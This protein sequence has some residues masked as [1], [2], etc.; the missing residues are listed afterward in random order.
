M[1]GIIG[2]TRIAQGCENPPKTAD[3][4]DKI[5]TSSH[6]L[7]GLV[8]DVLDMSRIE[9]GK[10]KLHPEPY[11]KREFVAYLEAVVRPLCDEKSQEFLIMDEGNPDTVAILDKLR[12][13]Q[14]VFNLLSNA[15]KYTPEGGTI[16][17]GISEHVAA[18]MTAFTISV[19]DNGIGI[20]EDFQKHLFEP[21]S[22][23]NRYYGAETRENSTG[24]GLPIVKQ[25]V[26]LMGGTL[27]VRSA[28]G[29]G[30]TFLIHLEASCKKTSELAAETSSGK[31]GLREG[32]SLVG[33]HV[34]LIEDHPLNAEI[35]TAILEDAGL[36]VT[37]A[38]NGKRGLDAFRASPVG[39]YDFVLM[40]IRM[41]VMD[42]Y[43]SSKAIRALDREDAAGV[44][45]IA[46][47]ADAFAD[48]VARCLA[49]G[50]D[51]HVPKP[52]D[53]DVLLRELTRWIG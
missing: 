38:E 44:P 12:I 1:N 15:I 52:V 48:D 21:F 11:P 10:I 43:E 20:D 25:L 28:K 26:S 37:Q 47:S 39:F 30:S 22:Q 19:R 49:A 24:L 23:E 16:T 53:P 7:L 29:E 18:D 4:L 14:I 17:C 31:A 33:K 34:L 27:E 5:A 42:G 40:D 51:A 2:M 3:C 9:S 32:A 36:A 45:I 13:N 8:N 46:M 6:F 35:A 50:M 41:P